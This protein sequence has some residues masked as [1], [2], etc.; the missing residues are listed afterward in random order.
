[1][2]SRE[3]SNE[4]QAT[5]LE[6]VPATDRTVARSWHNVSKIFQK[7][8]LEPEPMPILQKVAINS[9]NIVRSFPSARR[10]PHKLLRARGIVWFLPA[11]ITRFHALEKSMPRISNWRQRQNTEK[12]TRSCHNPLCSTTD[13]ELPLAASWPISQTDR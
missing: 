5:A 2:S 8:A 9:Q 12:S 1:M 7:I 10:A 3:V 11:L 6:A 13:S 4:G